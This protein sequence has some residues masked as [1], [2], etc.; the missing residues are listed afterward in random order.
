VAA[1]LDGSFVNVPDDTRQREQSAYSRRNFLARGGAVAGVAI[2]GGTLWA[3]GPGAGRARRASGTDGPIRHIIVSCQENRS[4]DHYY[5]FAPQVQAG[6][7][8]PGPGYTQPDASDG[9][10]APF[11]LEAL[12]SADPP[13]SWNPVHRQYN[14]GKMDGFYRTAQHDNGDGNQAMPFYTARELPFYYSLFSG[15]GLCANYFSSV[16]GPT[17]PNRYYLMSGTSGGITT[18]GI[19]GYGVFDSGGWPII[20]DLLDAAGV[21]WKIYNHYN[22]DVS[23]GDSNNVAVFWNRWAHDPRTIATKDDYLRDLASNRLPQVSWVVPSFTLGSDEHPSADVSAGMDFQQEMITALR[24][25]SAWQHAAFLLTYDEHGGFF[26]HV[27]PPRVDAYGLGVRVPLWVIAPHARRGVITSRL[28][29]DHASTLKFIERTFH[30]PTL[31]S[32]NHRFDLA[33]PAGDDHEANGASAPPR[34]GY[35]GLSDLYDLFDFP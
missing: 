19:W 17:L 27:P 4:F 31:A 22:D 8:G 20:L 25:S 10:H 2:L 35:R 12:T 32:Q 9:T 21:T 3:T 13:H 30:L 11:E 1:G 6:G 28:P 7:F 23:V 26:D 33:T 29:A 16:L 24:R 34:D 15:F 5:G 18:N 14:G